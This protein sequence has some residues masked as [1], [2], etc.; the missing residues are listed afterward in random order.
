RPC[1]R[2]SG[3]WAALCSSGD[4]DEILLTPLPLD[5]QDRGVVRRLLVVEV[6]APV[7]EE[8]LQDG[9][10]GAAEGRAENLAPAR[11]AIGSAGPIGGLEETVRA[12]DEDAPRGQVEGEVRVLP[13]GP[14]PEGETGESYLAYLAAFQEERIGM[15]GVGEEGLAGREVQAEEGETGEIAPALPVAEHPV[16]LLENR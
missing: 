12:E 3:A 14:L 13:L 15:A 8:G 9:L 10:G 1:A 7:G 2:F 5:H 6:A 16:D 4:F 11:V